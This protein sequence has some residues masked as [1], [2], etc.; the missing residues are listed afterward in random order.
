MVGFLCLLCHTF[1]TREVLEA[2]RLRLGQVAT[3]LNE[4]MASM[5]GMAG[6]ILDWPLH[7][8][9]HHCAFS[10]QD[11]TDWM[12]IQVRRTSTHVRWRHRF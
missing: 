8:H 4:S 9:T 6:R 10:E 5:A 7:N 12:G 11:R 1:C 2:A 3:L